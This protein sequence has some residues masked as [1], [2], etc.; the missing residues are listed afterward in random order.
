[1]ARRALHT[2][3]YWST[4]DYAKR[5][6]DN[7]GE[8]NIFFLAGGIAFNILLAAVPFLLL[9]VAGLATI[10]NQ[11]STA[12]SAEV[13]AL[14]SRLMPPQA[15]GGDSP[16][17]ALLDDILKTRGSVKLI[18]AIGFVWFST[19]LFGSLRSVLAEVFDIEQDR[20]IIDGKL[21]DIKITIIATLL[22]VGYSALNAYLAVAT[23]RGVEVL[24]E[25]GLR[26]E[27]MGQ[28]EYM[29]GRLLAIAFILTMFFSLYKFL[30]KR[31]VRWKTAM[32]AAG[33]TTAMFEIARNLFSAYVASFNPAS[34][35][36]G[37][38]TAIVIIVFWVYYAAL[39]FILGGE[40]GQVYE[41]RRVRRMQREV[42]TE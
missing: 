22:L 5:V 28:V 40:V 38:L 33:F 25:F 1:M 11:S 23:T 36:T 17:V 27:V 13:N 16:I 9:L 39:I 19:R 26:N 21:F 3:L 42:F 20:G 32:V 29:F 2:R 37:T 30:P 14:L 6:W 10:L 7:S 15:G 4:R 24:T 12:T 35:Y 31:R 8:D 18:S 41:L 34:L